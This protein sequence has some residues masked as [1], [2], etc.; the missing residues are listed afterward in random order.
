MKS[1]K[2]HLLGAEGETRA[3]NLLVEKGYSILQENWRF[4]KYEVDIIASF[5]DIIVFVEVK[6]RSSIGFGEPETFVNKKKQGFLV[7]AA[8]EYL[9]LNNIEFEC[10]FDV[11]SVLQINN[12][13]I[14]KHL[15]AAFYPSIK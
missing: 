2:S 12:T 11:V 8:N 6:S 5:R 3:K 10:R 13:F 14:V 9:I 15:E 4:K 7:S 1:K